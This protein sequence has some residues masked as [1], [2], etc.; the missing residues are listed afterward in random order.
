MPLSYWVDANLI[1]EAIFNLFP[2]CSLLYGVDRWLKE[3][4]IFP[5]GKPYLFLSILYTPNT[6][7]L[8]VSIRALCLTTVR[9]SL[10]TLPWLI[11]KIHI[12]L[13]LRVDPTRCQRFKTGRLGIANG[14]Y[15]CSSHSP[16]DVSLL[17]SADLI[18]RLQSYRSLRHKNMISE[19]H[20]SNHFYSNNNNHIYNINSVWCF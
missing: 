20:T 15:W 18:T 19:K 12:L 3:L 16:C 14:I 4:P 13:T 7:R 2:C 10:S 5:M 1:F 11:L 17:M 6:D 8:V 9:H